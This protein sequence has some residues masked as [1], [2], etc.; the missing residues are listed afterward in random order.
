[1]SEF[2][3]DPISGRWAIVAESRAAR[4]NEYPTR[5]AATPAEKCPFCPGHESW[6]PP[7]VAADREPGSLPDGP[8]WNVRAIPNKFPSLAA[9]ARLEPGGPPSE[10]AL[11]RP[12]WG[13]HEVVVAT[14][15][16]GLPLA[17]LPNDQVERVLRVLRERLRALAR[18]PAV[19]ACVA[20]ENSGPESGGT[21]FHPHL[22]VVA[23]P[24][25]PPRLGEEVDGLRR[26]S[27]DHG[28]ACGYEWV[29]SDE[30][31]RRARWVAET[32]AFVA[33][34]PFASEH[35][36][37]LRILPTRHGPSFGA[38]ADVEVRAL[39]E[40]LPALL[41]ALDAVVPGASYNLVTR[42]FADARPE[43]RD[44]H[45]HLDLLPRLVRADGFEVGGGIPVNP[46]SPESAAEALRN[47]LGGPNPRPGSAAPPS[48][49]N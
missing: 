27:R 17:R 8:G 3:Q 25:V 42:S 21:L 33:F 49:K 32:P 46:V 12:G 2:R 43:G 40:L 39:A 31:V 1:V 19:A 36:Y 7:E 20:F 14:P 11:R 45:W 22:Q 30:R 47:A 10:E 37:E 48:T 35:P 4:P 23:L 38:A 15:Q 24:D 18:D 41:R 16:H 13:R 28:A 9:D 26:F 6:T 34:S 44:Y 5:P 29:Q